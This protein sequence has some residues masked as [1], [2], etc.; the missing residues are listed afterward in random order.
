MKHPGLRNADIRTKLKLD[1]DLKF[2]SGS[3]DSLCALVSIVLT[4]LRSNSLL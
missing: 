2:S 3:Q 4:F 1:L